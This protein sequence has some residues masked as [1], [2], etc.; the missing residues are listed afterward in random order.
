MR[1]YQEKVFQTKLS[2]YE[3]PHNLLNFLA[4]FQTH[5]HLKVYL[6]VRQAASAM[7]RTFYPRACRMRM[8]RA[9]KE[10]QTICAI[11]PST[12]CLS[13]LLLLRQNRVESL[14]ARL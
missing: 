1:M 7:C 12:I 2:P 4:E 10:K 3:V 5:I 8:K 11:L 9:A 13:R 6:S 14:R